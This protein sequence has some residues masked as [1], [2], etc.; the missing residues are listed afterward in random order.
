[1]TLITA[2]KFHA[3]Q[4]LQVFGISEIEIAFRHFQSGR[5]SGKMVIEMRKHDK[6][7]VRIYVIFLLVERLLT[8]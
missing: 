6:I 1:M 5:N 4:P 7:H 8:N 3:P 2:K